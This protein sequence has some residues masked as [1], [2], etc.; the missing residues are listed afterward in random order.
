MPGIV[1][2]NNQPGWLIVAAIF[3]AIVALP[4]LKFI[5]WRLFSFDKKVEKILTQKK[6]SE[7]RLGKIAE[8]LSPLLDDFPVDVKKPG[9]STVYMG[10]PVDFVH[11]DPEEGITFIEVKS[12]GAKLTANQR[13]FQEMIESGKVFWAQMKV[14]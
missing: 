12:G 2:P 11:F 8:T 14:K 6:S 1:P 7:V 10:Q 13:K 5:I 9:T 4:I 3:F